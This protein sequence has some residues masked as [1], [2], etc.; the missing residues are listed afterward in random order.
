MRLVATFE[1]R[2]EARRYYNHLMN[3]GITSLFEIDEDKFQVWVH[4]EE[5]VEKAKEILAHFK[6]EPDHEKYDVADDTHMAQPSEPTE[7]SQDPVF[8]AR[9]QEMR[10]KMSAPM[11][12][13]NISAWVTKLTILLCV[14]LYV[15]DVYQRYD[16]VKD[17]KEPPKNQIFTPLDRALMFDT[18]NTSDPDADFDP[19]DEQG[20]LDEAMKQDVWIG[21][22][23]IAL[24][25]PE[26]KPALKAPMFVKIREGQVWRLVTPAVLH[27][28]ILHIL[29]NMLWVWL[30]GKQI[31]ERIGRWRYILLMVIVALVANV[32]QY[33]MVGPNFLGFSG[34]ICGMAGFIWMRQRIAPWEGYPLH[35]TAVLFL[36]IFVLGI[37]GLQ[38]VSFVL[39]LMNLAA[40]PIQLANTAHLIG[41]LSGIVLAKVPLFGRINHER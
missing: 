26:S 39:N 9:I 37:A 31:E 38:V 24:Y 30:L 33:I 34:V 40:L 17:Y 7:I 8:L 35:R 5:D 14:V 1:D 19:S 4:N 20:Q 32:C 18:P 11:L 12:Y 3:E 29:F 10:K 6:D 23:Y 41:A 2:D 22:Y 15:F 16:I 21:L 27:G 25:W 36:A 13:S 28:G